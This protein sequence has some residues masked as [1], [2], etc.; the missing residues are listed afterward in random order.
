MRPVWAMACSTAQN[1]SAV[2]RISFA[3]KQ[4]RKAERPAAAAHE[5]YITVLWHQVRS[6][7]N[8]LPNGRANSREADRFDARAE[9]GHKRSLGEDAVHRVE[10]AT[11]T[12]AS[13]LRLRS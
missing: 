11:S 8:S 9:V 7:S 2:E 10:S 12:L 4:R 1:R 6:P 3:I 5:N 13:H